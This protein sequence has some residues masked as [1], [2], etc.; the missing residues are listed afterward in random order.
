MRTK[1][2][3]IIQ[4]YYKT[5]IKRKR[6]GNLV[7]DTDKK[8]NP[9]LADELFDLGNMDKERRKSVR[10]MSL[11][12]LDINATENKNRKMDMNDVNTLEELMENKSKND[13]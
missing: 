5:F 12:K 7:V 11:S 3:L 4:R 6:N 1:A 9:K 13:I 8:D 2:I 10:T